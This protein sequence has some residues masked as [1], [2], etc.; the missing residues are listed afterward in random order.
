MTDSF[1]PV[2][3]L[4]PSSLSLPSQFHTSLST[5]YDPLK[6]ASYPPIALLTSRATPTVRGILSTSRSTIAAEGV[7]RLTWAQGDGIVLFESASRLPGDPEVRG[8]ERTGGEADGWT[9]HLK[10]VVE[11]SNGHVSLCSDLE[12][13]RQCLQM[14]YG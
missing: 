4:P 11:S 12:G 13:V 6:S 1:I 5:L 8:E 14:L 7:E 2:I 10:G 3:S 9:R